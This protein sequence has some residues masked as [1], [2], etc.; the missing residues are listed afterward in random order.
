MSKSMVSKS[1]VSKSMKKC[2]EMYR[3]L[4]SEVVESLSEKYSFDK[5]EALEYLHATKR[6][7]EPKKRETTKK[8]NVMKASVVLP[9]LGVQK[10][11]CQAIVQNGGLY[12]QCQK[13]RKEG[14]EYCT[15][16]KRHSEIEGLKYGTVKERVEQ[17]SEWKA[18]NGKKPVEYAKVMLKKKITKEAAM[19]EAE[20]F[21]WV[22]TEE[23]LEMEK[24]QEGKRGRPAKVKGVE[25]ELSGDDLIAKLVA[26]AAAAEEGSEEENETEKDT[27]MAEVEKRAEEEAKKK[28]REEAVNKVIAVT[29]VE[30]EDV[31]VEVEVTKKKVVRRTKKTDEEKEAEKKAKEEAKAAEKAKKEAEKAAE[32]AKKEA[33]KA[34]AKAAKEAE[35]KAKEEKKMKELAEKAEAEKKLVE[36][37]KA[38]AAEMEKLQAEMKN[39]EL[40][41]GELEEEDV[42]EQVE[43]VQFTHK[44]VTYLRDE[45]N[46]VYDMATQDEVG[47]WNE[48]TEEI[49]ALPD[50]EDEKTKNM[51]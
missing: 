6:K 46:V 16:C 7:A 39:Q 1:M 20:R 13:V 38:K 47:M 41:D 33:E 23:H 45:N 11:L 35:K 19:S 26:E 50:D 36:A 30:K 5:E 25:T 27:T 42:E 48:E 14:E 8:V 34:A 51:D 21:G 15:I 9:F 40:E 28:E 31:E 37:E 18:P 32:K 3:E 24:K 17:G 4:C 2:E 44:G 12:T 10:E 49:D 43:V 22:L 29:G